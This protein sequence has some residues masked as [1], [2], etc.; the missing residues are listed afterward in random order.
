MTKQYRMSNN[1]SFYLS[2]CICIVLVGTRYRELS[3]HHGVV[4]SY[5]YVYRKCRCQSDY[6]L[7]D[8]RMKAP[9]PEQKRVTSIAYD[10]LY[11]N[12]PP[13]PSVR[14]QICFA[15]DVSRKRN[16]NT[17]LLSFPSLSLSP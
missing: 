11:H 6:I 15:F 8:E 16:G 7:R 14:S 10:T 1:I 17:N 2:E 12:V 4:F 9:L 13:P 5:Y 3:C